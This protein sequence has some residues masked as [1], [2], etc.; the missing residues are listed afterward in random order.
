MHTALDQLISGW[1]KSGER[2]VSLCRASACIALTLPIVGLEVACTCSIGQQILRVEGQKSEK[3]N[4]SYSI[5]LH[6]TTSYSSYVEGK[7][8]ISR[9][10]MILFF[11]MGSQTKAGKSWMTRRPVSCPACTVKCEVTC[12]Q[13]LFVFQLM[14]W[15]N[16]HDNHFNDNGTP[17]T[18]S[19]LS[20]PVMAMIATTKQ[21]S[22]WCT[23]STPFHP[24]NSCKCPILQTHVSHLVHLECCHVATSAD[25]HLMLMTT[26]SLSTPFHTPQI[27]ASHPCG[28]P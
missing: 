25:N 17:I 9:N 3:I 21:L 8:E 16:S 7:K 18:H 24:L 15:L 14:M 20:S 13:I 26:C 19:T 4:F 2:E 27:H 12:L 5:L 23:T 11:L 1:V 22:S 6:L 10:K 28:K